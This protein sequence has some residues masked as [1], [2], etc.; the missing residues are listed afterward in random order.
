MPLFSGGPKNRLPRRHAVLRTA[1]KRI[2][3]VIKTNIE[4][5]VTGYLEPTGTMGASCSSM[6]SSGDGRA[7]SI[8]RRQGLPDG[9]R[10]TVNSTGSI[11]EL[12]TT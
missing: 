5:A 3:L 12:H 1:A 2:Y 6:M 7:V 4:W 11:Q 10:G 9:E 8:T